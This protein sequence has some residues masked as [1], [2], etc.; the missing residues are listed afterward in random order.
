M[1]D[2]LVALFR[3]YTIEKLGPFVEVLHEYILIHLAVEENTDDEDYMDIKNK[4]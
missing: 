3:A 1:N 4:V 2:Q